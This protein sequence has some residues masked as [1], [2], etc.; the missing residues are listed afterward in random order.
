MSYVQSAAAV[1]GKHLK[2]GATVI[3]ESSVYP[4]A[5]EEIVKPTIERESG[6][7]CGQ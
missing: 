5:T 4:G 6:Y 7:I 1:I 2:K 3:M